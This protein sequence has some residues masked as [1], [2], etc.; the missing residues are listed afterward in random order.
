MSVSTIKMAGNSCRTFTST[1]GTSQF[2]LNR[3]RCFQDGRRVVM[4][5]DA[6]ANNAISTGSTMPL[7]LVPSE[8]APSE[9]LAG[10][11]WVSNGTNFSIGYAKVFKNGNS[12]Y[13]GQNVYGTISAGTKLSI[14]CEYYI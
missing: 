3:Q 11:G 14:Y 10:L 6:T 1:L 7:L 9:D 8:L 2:T 12:Y 5:F 13:V 4:S